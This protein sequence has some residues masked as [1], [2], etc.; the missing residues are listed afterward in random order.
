MFSRRRRIDRRL[1]PHAH[2]LPSVFTA[3]MNEPPNDADTTSSII[4]WVS[5][6]RWSSRRQAVRI[7]YLPRSTDCRLFYRR[8]ISFRRI[9]SRDV[10]HYLF[11][12]SDFC[13]S[14]AELTLILSPH[15]HRLPSFITNVLTSLADMGDILI[16]D[17][18]V[19]PNVSPEDTDVFAVSVY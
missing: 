14:V 13:R 12:S 16:S 10:V 9:Y 19:I 8:R 15:A 2:R 17:I 1:Y 6:S 3:I 4:F 5:I 18:S 11:G 7:R